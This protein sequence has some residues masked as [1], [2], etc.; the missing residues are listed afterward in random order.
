VASEVPLRGP[1]EPGQRSGRFHT[2]RGPMPPSAWLRYPAAWARARLG[3]VPERPWIVPAAV[4]WLRRRIRRDWSVLELGAGRSTAWFADRAGSVISFEDNEHWLRRTAELLDRRGLEV[5]L[6]LMPVESFA[7]AVEALPDGAFDLVVLDF[8][9]SPQATRVDL[10]RPARE[11]V[12]LRGLLLLD[13]SDRPGYA[14]AYELLAGWRERRFV[15]VKDE[16][17]QACETAIFRRPS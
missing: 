1:H 10:L 2:A 12:R 15:G 8:L 7:G 11:V 4:G 13:D 9:E 14:E 6:R 16:W 17:P 3:S 5:D